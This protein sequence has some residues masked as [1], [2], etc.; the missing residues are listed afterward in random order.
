MKRPGWQLPQAVLPADLLMNKQDREPYLK[1]IIARH[2]PRQLDGQSARIIR[3]GS[4]L[5]AWAQAGFVELRDC[6]SHARNTSTSASSE[7]KLLLL[8]SNDCH[9]NAGGIRASY[10]S[11]HGYLIERYR[12]VSKLG[13]AI[14]VHLNGMDMDVTPA[15][16][17]PGHTDDHQ[18]YRSDDGSFLE[19]NVIGH[20]V[21]VLEADRSDETRLLKIWFAQQEVK[22]ASIYVDYLV[23]GKLLEGLKPENDSLPTNF[24][25]M[26]RHL[27]KRDFNPLFEDL[28][29]P[30][31]PE[32]LFSALMP[33]EEKRKVV[34]AAQKALIERSIAGIIQ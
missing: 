12:D 15:R 18:L 32:N 14:R 30:S 19:T 28:P 3:L 4:D 21:D 23:P 26:L 7:V 10:E 2:L 24:M 27:A 31:N 20:V 13:M 22:S 33:D 8:L 11:L 25:R 5:M 9:R 17:L 16:L 6:G 29:D 1:D 34:K